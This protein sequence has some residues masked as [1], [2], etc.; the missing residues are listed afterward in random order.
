MFGSNEQ[1]ALRNCYGRPALF[2][3]VLRVTSLNSGPAWMVV[4]VPSAS[5]QK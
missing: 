4:D 3:D 1:I 2:V 5:V